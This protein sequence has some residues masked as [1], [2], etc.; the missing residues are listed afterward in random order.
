MNR[1][2]RF[3]RRLLGLN[4]ILLALVGGLALWVGCHAET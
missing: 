1:D 4:A 2:R 3:E